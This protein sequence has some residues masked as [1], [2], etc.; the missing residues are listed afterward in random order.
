MSFIGVEIFTTKKTVYILT[1]KQDFKVG[2]W[3]VFE[4][5]DGFEIGKIKFCVEKELNVQGTNVRKATL[6]DIEE[7]RKR[8]NINRE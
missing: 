8:E 7:F 1:N 6:K 3:C 5:Q 2:E 4:M